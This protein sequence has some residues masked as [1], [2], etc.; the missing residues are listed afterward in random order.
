MKGRDSFS[1]L[2]VPRI[3]LVL[4]LLLPSVA[5]YYDNGVQFINDANYTVYVPF[6]ASNLTIEA[7]QIIIDLSVLDETPGTNNTILVADNCSE[8]AT[9]SVRFQILNESDLSAPTNA[10]MEAHLWVSNGGYT[11]EFNLTWTGY[12]NSICILGDLS[13]FSL[14]VQVEYNADGYS[15]ETFYADSLAIN[16]TLQTYDLLLSSG[17]T[18]VTFTVKDQF[19]DVVSDI[20]IEILEYEIGEDA[21]TLTQSIKTNDDGEAIGKVTLSTKRYKFLLKQDGDLLLETDAV[22]L[23]LTSYTFRV[24]LG[25]NYFEYYDYVEDVACSITRTGQTYEYTFNDPN[26]QITQGCLSITLRTPM[27]DRVIN[28]SCVAGY[29]GSISKNAYTVTG[30]YTIL[31]Q[32][33]FTLNGQEYYCTQTTYTKSDNADLF[34]ENGIFLTF[35][36]VLTLAMIGIWSPSASI[37][38]SLVAVVLSVVFGIFTLSTPAVLVLVILGIISIAR[39]T[40]G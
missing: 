27:N 20:I 26:E 39:I 5:A 1:S 9:E 21:G 22:I 7:S 33:T 16:G 15:A 38:L 2:I 35:F 4:L 17:T 37:V 10:T 8:Y 6:S 32:G 14:D 31:A 24:N 40:K 3:L 18:D 36:V 28:S 12:N 25:G 34:G 13:T 30:S 29:T 19:D 11:Q 23:T